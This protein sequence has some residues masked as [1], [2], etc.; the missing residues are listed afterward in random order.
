MS[1]FV[2]VGPADDIDEGGVMAYEA[3]GRQVAVARADGALYAF[4]D[5]CTHRNCTLSTGE[6][7]GTEIECEC[8]GSVFD[9]ATGV[10]VNGPATDPIE[11]FD[12]R[13]EDG[14]VQVNL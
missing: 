9:I 4:S 10:V 3:E 6:L 5:I 13:E 7:D 8:H 1:E 14:N 11:T 12:V 2:T